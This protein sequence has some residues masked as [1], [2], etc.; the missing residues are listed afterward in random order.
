MIVPAKI[1]M[2]AFE[3]SKTIISDTLMDL[4]WSSSTCKYNGSLIADLIVSV[5]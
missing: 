3:F 4:E 5:T 1:A 2:A